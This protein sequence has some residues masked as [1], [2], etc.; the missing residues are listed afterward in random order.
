MSRFGYDLQKTFKPLLMGQM[1]VVVPSLI[2]NVYFLSVYTDRLNSKYFTTFF[3]ALVSVM[4]IY[5]FCWY[6]NEI[7]LNVS[8]EWYSNSIIP[9]R[10]RFVR[11]NERL[12]LII[13]MHINELDGMFLLQ[14]MNLSDALYEC[15]WT[16]FNKPTR[17]DLLTMITRTSKA[18]NISAVVAI[19]LNIDSFIQVSSRF[20]KFDAMIIRH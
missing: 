8:T 2:I 15:N 10:I 12:L 4:Q 3:F 1:V 5:M 20:C 11:R 14:S 7:V 6:G 13:F 16:A 17:K 19:P 9:A 18:V